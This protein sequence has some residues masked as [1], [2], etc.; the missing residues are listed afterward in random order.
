M[1]QTGMTPTRVNSDSEQDQGDFL[2]D[3]HNDDADANTESC[4]SG[5]ATASDELSTSYSSECCRNELSEPYH[6]TSIL[7]HSESR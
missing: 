1:A 7:L 6:P 5:T 3:L 2:D 4:P